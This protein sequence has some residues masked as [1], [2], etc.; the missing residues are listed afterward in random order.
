VV[1]TETQTNIDFSN[2][3]RKIIYKKLDCL[4]AKVTRCEYTFVKIVKQPRRRL[5]AGGDKISF[6]VA[7]TYTCDGDGDEDTC[8]AAQKQ[9][10]TQPDKHSAE[11]VGKLQSESE[12]KNIKPK[13]DRQK[14][15][16]LEPITIETIQDQET[17]TTGPMGTVTKT[18]GNDATT[19]T[20]TT[21]SVGRNV[22][23]TTVG[24]TV[25]KTTV[26]TTVAETI[27][28]ID[29]APETA[30]VDAGSRNKSELIAAILF[31]ILMVC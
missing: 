29:G 26:G 11:V 24:T 1:R 19:V 18:T 5:Q 28:G 30:V 22:T 16:E 8:T 17:A 4:K 6:N 25:A 31:V 23:K 3:A 13:L 20:T 2:E 15:E 27:G 9:L 7:A 14:T 10:V 21:A 12:F